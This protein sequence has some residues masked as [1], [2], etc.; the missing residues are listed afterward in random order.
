MSLFPRIRELHKETQ[1]AVFLPKD[2]ALMPLSWGVVEYKEYARFRSYKLPAPEEITVPASKM[3]LNRKSARD[4]DPSKKISMQTLS[5]LLYW[6]VGVRPEE[7]KEIDFAHA[8]RMYPSAGG[9]YPCEI[10]IS[11]AGNGEIS[12]GVYH[13]NV[14]KHS[15][16]EVLDAKGDASVRQFPN[17]P[18][19]KDAPLVFFITGMFARD[20]YKY[21]E[22]GYRFVLLEAGILIEALYLVSATQNLS[23]CA[24]GSTIDTQFETLLNLNPEEES[25]LTHLVIG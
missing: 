16:E 19:V 9:R 7:G 11:F 6:S 12:A 25:M 22:R 24:L 1:K 10:Y 15:L 5:N 8:H 4:F 2:P 20:M 18:F 21:K 13:Y 17:Y 23:V 3:F 14:K